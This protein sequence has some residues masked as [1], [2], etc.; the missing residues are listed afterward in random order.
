MFYAHLLYRTDPF[1]FLFVDTEY[2]NKKPYVDMNVYPEIKRK[3]KSHD[4]NDANDANEFR[5]QR[6]KRSMMK[7]VDF[8]TMCQGVLW[9]MCLEYLNLEDG[10]QTI[11]LNQYTAGPCRQ[12]HKEWFPYLG[13]Q[14]GRTYDAFIANVAW[15]MQVPAPS[16]Y[17]VELPAIWPKDRMTEKKGCGFLQRLQHGS[18]TNV[19]HVGYQL[20]SQ[21]LKD[22][23]LLMFAH[24]KN[25]TTLDLFNSSFDY[26]PHLSDQGMCIL[27]Q[28]LSQL[29]KVRFKRLGNIT[30]QTLQ[31]LG[32]LPKLWYLHVIRC[33]K[34]TGE[35][36]LWSGPST[37]KYVRV[38]DCSG[39]TD[40][41]IVQWLRGQQSLDTIKFYGC[42]KVRGEFLSGL[43]ALSEVEEIVLDPCRH[44]TDQGLQFLC[45]QSKLRKLIMNS[46]RNMTDQ[47]LQ[48]LCDC[49]PHIKTLCLKNCFLLTDIGIQSLQ[50]LSKLENVDLSQNR[51]LTNHALKPLAMLKSLQ[52]VDLE[53]CTQTTKRGV[54][55]LRQ[56]LSGTEIWVD[57]DW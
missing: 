57:W 9:G 20:G 10:M 51:Q 33:D 32:Q 50:H 1:H 41:G 37:L 45:Q 22:R 16:A 17:Q 14:E 47:G 38:E 5:R 53:G 23:S 39:F 25:L 8:M 15:R 52:F 24:L 48:Q 18:L 13:R 28:H 3:R 12:G 44:A 6:P 42:S 30:D 55:K 34:I 11:L 21:I 46:C 56:T 7:L 40:T 26:S 35:N 19:L 36:V 2:K 49:L 29:Q 4:T 54:N 27:T 31:S 43:S